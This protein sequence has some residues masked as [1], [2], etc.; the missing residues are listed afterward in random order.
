[1]Q[2][3]QLVTSLETSQKLKALWIKQ[4]SYFHYRI[5]EWKLHWTILT[6][7]LLEQY[8]FYRKI[9]ISAFTSAEL[10]EMLPLFEIRKKW[11]DYYRS[12]SA[13]LKEDDYFMS[14][15]EN[16]AESMWKLYIY[17]KENNLV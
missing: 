10:W 2:L 12:Y 15:E 13:L 5:D 9:S 16:M 1:M 3:S 4:E 11:P 14:D 7:D 17:L 6:A 8:P